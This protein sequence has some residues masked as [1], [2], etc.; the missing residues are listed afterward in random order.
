MRAKQ[1]GWHSLRQF[2][3]IMSPQHSRM[4][5]ALLAGLI[6]SGLNLLAP[7]LIGYG[8]D[9]FIQSRQYPGLIQLGGV[10]LGI[11]LLALGAHYTQMILM[12]TVG[13]NVLFE[14]RQRIFN[15]LQ[16][17]PVSF[18]N[19]HKAGDLISRINNDSDKLNQFLSESL[20]RFM[21]SLFIMAGAGLAVLVL[22]PRLG[23]VALT[24]SLL[25]L[26]WTRLLSPWVKKQNA[27]Q[28]EKT[29]GLSAVIQESLSH[30]KELL[31]FDRRDYFRSH[32]GE[33]NAQN[34]RA[35]MGSGLANS[36]FG[37]L[38][39]LHYNL[40]TLG[41]LGYGLWL[42]LQ[43]Q[44]S[45]GI[46]ISFLSYVNRYYDPLRQMAMLWASFQLALASWERI[47]GILEA[48]DSLPILPPGPI[49]ADAGLLCFKSVCFQYPTGSEVLHQVNF[50][51]EA[52]KTYALVGPTGGGKSTTAALMARLY[53]P[54][55][56]QIL[57]QGRDLRSLTA[58][59]R[60]SHVGFILQEP[61]LL[62][63]T[64]RDNLVLGHPSLQKASE[65]ELNDQLQAKGLSDFLS[66]FAQGLETPVGDHEN[67]TSL[68]QKQLLAFMRAVLR[69]PDLLILDEATANIDTVTEQAL[70]EILSRLPAH[71]TRVI[72]AHRLNTIQNADQIFFVNGGQIQLAGSFEQAVALLMQETRTS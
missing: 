49:E 59:E 45:V 34:Y 27:Q 13:Q 37:P 21:G 1:T 5:L 22:N 70:S 17:L 47:A 72:I 63:G 9:Q 19:Q 40:A 24:P 6:N 56:G 36:I 54:T 60:S 46:L 38:F 23:L 12:G 32:F 39:D 35:S 68:G 58:K 66:R 16:T 15:Q 26:V 28:L 42:M 53:D 65:S 64:V 43:G 61:F 69:E 7:F 41:V 31:V 33:F 29:G 20:V 62:A 18:F 55:S 4:L 30:F 50:Q 51:L 11:Y 25:L 71:T 48:P 57:F 52:G 14:L 10:L 8:I 67:Q 3:R 2:W 44:L